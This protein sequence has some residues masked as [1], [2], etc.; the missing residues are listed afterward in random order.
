MMVTF[1][2][3][4]GKNSLTHKKWKWATSEQHQEEQQW[5]EWDIKKCERKSFRM[6]DEAEK[7]ELSSSGVSREKCTEMV[8]TWEENG[9]G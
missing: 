8:W 2:R 5:I 9:R 4:L 7:D 3:A 1:G 6:A